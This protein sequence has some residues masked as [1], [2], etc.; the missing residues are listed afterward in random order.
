LKRLAKNF[1]FKFVLMV[2]ELLIFEVLEVSGEKI[3][4]H[5]V[6]G[7]KSIKN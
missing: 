6:I 5:F 2:S 1:S 3:M 7:Q 4:D